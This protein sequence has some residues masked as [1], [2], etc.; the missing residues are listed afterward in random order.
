MSIVVVEHDLEASV[1]HLNGAVGQHD[2]D[3]DFENYWHYLGIL[4][5]HCGIL[6]ANI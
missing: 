4:H 5:C 1:D 2:T 6:Q 3:S